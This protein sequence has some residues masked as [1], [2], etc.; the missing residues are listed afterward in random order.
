MPFRDTELDKP[1]LQDLQSAIPTPAVTASPVRPPISVAPV[2][3]AT[4]VNYQPDVPFVPTQTVQTYPA[5]QQM[6]QY[7][8]PSPE[9]ERT[10]STTIKDPTIKVA[11][12]REKLAALE[13]VQQNVNAEQQ[14]TE[15]RMQAH[16]EQ[17][18]E[19][20][21]RQAEL[22]SAV[23]E[24]KTAKVIDPQE[25]W[26]TGKK[27][28]AA[29]A[30]GL[31]AF[32]ASYGGGKNYA[33][34]I[35]N[36]SIARDIALQERDL[37]KLG[38]NVDRR[39]NALAR[40]YDKLKD[41]DQAKTAVTIAALT[42]AK[43]DVMNAAK[44]ID[45]AQIRARQ[46]SLVAAIESKHAEA[47]AQNSDKT[48]IQTATRQAAPQL[49]NAGVEKA[50][51]PLTD[52]QAKANMFANAMMNADKELSKHEAYATS[53]SGG[54]GTSKYIPEAVRSEKAKLYNQAANTWR[55]AYDR[56]T[57]G[58]AISKEEKADTLLRAMPQ[59]GDTPKVL[60]QK[61]VYRA[62][63]ANDIR[64]GVIGTS[65]SVQGQSDSDKLKAQYGFRGQ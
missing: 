11:Q 45:N 1:G 34:E 42:N 23:D 15:F 62:K 40:A 28:G 5:E 25:K 35:I 60:E 7:F 8:K 65:Q 56:F 12:E 64:T 9:T 29:I 46:S 31:G 3:R 63:I 38:A 26:G 41:I 18:A 14:L 10:V 24:L 27:I 22:Q 19:L 21:Q 50:G 6:P 39:T 13:A 55:E 20:S 53:V 43:Q 58:A 49:A 36:D 47:I 51:K 37:Q 4:P 52:V 59:V 30:M 2:A 61:R 44:N 57:S 48:I 54:I 17:A 32:A 33:A 16:A